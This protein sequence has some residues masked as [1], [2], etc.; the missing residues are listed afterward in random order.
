MNEQ[1]IEKLAKLAGFYADK[2]GQ[3]KSQFGNVLV[4]GDDFIDLKKFAEL[5]VKECADE[6][7][8]FWCGPDG[9]ENSAHDHILKHF[10]VEQ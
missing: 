8:D 7:F 3:C 9:E 5:I 4:D 6:A 10:G 2:Y 1:L